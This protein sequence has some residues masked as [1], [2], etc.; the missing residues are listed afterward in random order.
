[1]MFL[2]CGNDFALKMLETNIAKTE[3]F[4]KAEYS[5]TYQQLILLAIQYNVY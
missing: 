2:F 5:D 3:K 1:M 4:S